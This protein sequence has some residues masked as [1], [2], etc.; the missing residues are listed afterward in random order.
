MNNTSRS[1][2]EIEKQLRSFGVTIEP[3]L[4][5]RELAAAEERYKVTFNPEH[6][7]FLRAML[8]VG[9]G[10]WDWRSDTDALRNAISQP[11]TS[12]LELVGDGH[13]WWSAWGEPPARLEE[14][15][16]LVESDSAHWARLV[17]LRGHRYV[18]ELISG[19][20][21][22]V[23]SVVDDDIVTY[24]RSIREYLDREYWGV[25]PAK[26]ADDEAV[27][28]PLYAPWSTWAFTP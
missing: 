17:P 13:F 25:A 22:P 15:V 10:W 16:S 8:P 11:T 3:G 12:I 20:Q 19:D 6:R 28:S 14:R 4:T 26:M 18:P 2:S 23:F 5:D 9:R 7:S 1:T 21:S 24:G 27:A